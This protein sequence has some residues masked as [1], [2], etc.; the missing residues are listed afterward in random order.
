MNS[1]L[2]RWLVVTLA[3]VGLALAV[4]AVGA[5]GDEPT[6]TD[7][8]VTADTPTNDTTVWPAWMQDHMDAH[9]GPAATE[10]MESHVGV[11]NGSTQDAAGHY[12]ADEDT[13]DSHWNDD[14]HDSAWADEDTRDRHWDDDTRVRGTYGHGHGC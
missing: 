9:M 1:T 5:H 8:T 6:R 2:G 4:P 7:G 14:T 13:R 10:W 11:A 3:V 12:W